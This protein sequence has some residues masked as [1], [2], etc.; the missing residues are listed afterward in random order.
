VTEQTPTETTTPAPTPTQTTT[1]APTF[2][3]E[4]EAEL[5]RRMAAARRDGEKAGKQAAE[6]AAA[7]AKKQAEDEAERKRQTEA[8]EFDK[9]RASLETERDGVKAERD[10][11]KETVAN[12]E[13]V[14]GPIVDERFKA[15]EALGD[16][17]IL[18]AYPKDADA[19]AK[20]AWLDD[21]RLK[22]LLARADDDPTNVRR[23]P[24]TPRPNDGK[25]SVEDEKRALVQT[26]SY[27]M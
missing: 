26:G 13:T 1:P 23:F 10:A 24:R 18:A 4:Q 7:D 25:P 27:R 15:L 9:V 11:L 14:I 2:T 19:L 20:L 12:Y 8:G 22:P 17:D 3:A 6:Q 16:K 21:P 5:N